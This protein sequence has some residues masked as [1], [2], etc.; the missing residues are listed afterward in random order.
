M[1]WSGAVDCGEEGIFEAL[2]CDP[3]VLVKCLISDGKSIRLS[4]L[5]IGS[6]H[7]DEVLANLHFLG[8]L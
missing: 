1:R 8:Q 5:R 7:T 2:G 4:I 6:L 3:D